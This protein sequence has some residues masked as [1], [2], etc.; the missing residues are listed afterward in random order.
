MEVRVWEK[1]LGTD[2]CETC[3]T[4][5]NEITIDAE[6][7]KWIVQVLV[8]CYGGGHHEGSRAEAV[9]YLRERWG[10][11]IDGDELD[12]LE[13]K[14][15][16]AVVETWTFPLQV[17][18]FADDSFVDHEYLDH[19]GD[20]EVS[21]LNDEWHVIVNTMHIDFLKSTHYADGTWDDIVK[22]FSESGHLYMSA[23]RLQT[24][25]QEIKAGMTCDRPHREQCCTG[26]GTHST[27][28]RQ[29]ILR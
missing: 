21:R 6:D 17:T 7:D 24:A 1:F 23:D 9:A 13:T 18:E 12:R 10:H 20:L 22:W 25:L 27:P 5:F 15:D 3:G 8:G 2:D 16:E 19:V 26:H 29:C 11:L 14:V 4:N 28:H